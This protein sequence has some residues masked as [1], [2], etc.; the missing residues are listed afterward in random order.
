MFAVTQNKKLPEASPDKEEGAK[1]AEQETATFMQ[2]TCSRR[3]TGT[4]TAH[5]FPVHVKW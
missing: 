1:A 4:S 2:D 5:Q 3:C